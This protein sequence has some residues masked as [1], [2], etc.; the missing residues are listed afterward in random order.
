MKKN[1]FLVTFLTI[2][3]LFCGT[4]FS[5]TV[6]GQWL[7]TNIDGGWGL[8]TFS[9]T[10]NPTPP[11]DGD[12]SSVCEEW[13]FSPGTWDDLV[14][15]ITPMPWGSGTFTGDEYTY[16][17]SLSIILSSGGTP[18]YNYNMSNITFNL[19]SP[20]T[21]SGTYDYQITDLTGSPVG[22]AVLDYE[23][24]GSMVPIPAAVWLLGTGF[25]GLVGIKRKD[26]P[27]IEVKI[28]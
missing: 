7:L 18:V 20:T 28:G 23:F 16:S 25:I 1:I 22:P 5:Y 10:L 3:F 27:K 14:P 13:H 9:S 12:F 19:T 11:P 2:S 21:L 6:D 17:T 24:Q 4:A 15:P 8:F 26:T